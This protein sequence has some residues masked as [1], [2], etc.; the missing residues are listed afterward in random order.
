[1]KACVGTTKEVRRTIKQAR[2]AGLEIVERSKEFLEVH[3]EG[4]LIY[5]ALRKGS[6]G[7]YWL[8]RYD[9]DSFSN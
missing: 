6:R 5:A 8:V 1:M 3:D 2:A 4:V 9:P 7:K